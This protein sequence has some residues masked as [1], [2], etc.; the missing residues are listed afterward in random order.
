MLMYGSD[1]RVGECVCLRAK[2]LDPHRRAITVRDAKG[3]SALRPAS[4]IRRADA[5]GPDSLRPTAP[6]RSTPP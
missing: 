2:D 5:A 3:H 1:L 4:A 6:S